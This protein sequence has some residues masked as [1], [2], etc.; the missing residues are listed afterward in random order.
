MKSVTFLQ[1]IN[2]FSIYIRENILSFVLHE[3][4]KIYQALNHFKMFR[5]FVNIF[6]KTMYCCIFQW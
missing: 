3:V 1:H 2:V 6:L 5:T 4:L